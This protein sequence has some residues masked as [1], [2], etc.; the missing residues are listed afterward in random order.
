MG[1]SDLTI[2]LIKNFID[3]YSDNGYRH[4]V[5]TLVGLQASNFFVQTEISIR[6]L[7]LLVEDY[8]DLKAQLGAQS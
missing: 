5:E 7:K 3:V 2:E 1:R 4:Q 8:E 6:D